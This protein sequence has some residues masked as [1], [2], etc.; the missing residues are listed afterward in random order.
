MGPSIL[1]RAAG[2]H[3]PDPSKTLILL[4]ALSGGTLLLANS[5][6]SA[7]GT[8]SGGSD[9][10]AVVA[11]VT[12]TSQVDLSPANLGF[13][14]VLGVSPLGVSQPDVSMVVLF[15]GAAVVVALLVCQYL[16][17][18]LFKL[19]LI[20]AVRGLEASRLG[21]VVELG[22]LR[23]WIFLRRF[24][25][26]GLSVHN[27]EGYH[28]DHM[29]RFRRALADFDLQSCLSSLGGEVVIPTLRLDG[30][31]CIVEE[32]A[33][34]NRSEEKTNVQDVLARSAYVAK[35][36]S[37]KPRLLIRKVVITDVSA[38]VVGGACTALPNMTYT[39][40]CAEMEADSLDKVVDALVMEISKAAMAGISNIPRHT[41]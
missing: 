23:T 30:V 29:I 27:P 9:G 12:G 8:T 1:Q 41:S 33:A 11:A 6:S 22:R 14:P 13:A 21:L 31:T 40:F 5:R 37:S 36:P 10:A 4:L 25:M 34:S 3:W 7:A 20:H 32:H 16:S 15:A 26:R 24:E 19:F 28:S 35:S 18:K 2:Q 38:S 17:E 39:D